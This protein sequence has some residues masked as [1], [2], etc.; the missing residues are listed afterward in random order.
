MIFVFWQEIDLGFASGVKALRSSCF[1]D[2]S[3]DWKLLVPSEVRIKLRNNASLLTIGLTYFQKRC[4][5]P[6]LVRA[7]FKQE[8]L[9]ECSRTALTCAKPPEIW[10]VVFTSHWELPEFILGL[11]ICTVRSLF[12]PR[13]DE[14]WKGTGSKECWPIGDWLFT[15]WQSCS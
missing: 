14:D 7:T 6:S 9:F 12:V 8:E 15:N 13:S 3:N 4:F 11:V 10:I 5:Q 1:G 2:Q